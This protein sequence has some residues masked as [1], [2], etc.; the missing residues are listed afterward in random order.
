[1][2]ADDL[3]HQAQSV[4]QVQLT[5]CAM[6][7][8]TRGSGAQ[9][10]WEAA[11]TLHTDRLTLRPPRVDDRDDV[12]AT[13]DAEVC[14]WQG[15]DDTW[16]KKWAEMFEGSYFRELAQHKPA[17]SPRLV[18]CESDGAVI[19][20]YMYGA[21]R[22]DDKVLTLGWWLG[23]SGRGRGL[24]TESLQAILEFAH[25]HGLKTI[26]MGTGID[27]ARARRQIESTGAEVT[28]Q[29]AHQLPNGQNVTAIWYRHHGPCPPA[30]PADA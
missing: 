9:R 21:P 13:I 18:V 26:E 23:A 14:R 4:S 2:L 24:G 6:R 17:I 25:A 22:S 10:R 8:R 30:Q 16:L 15:Y 7:A 19:G 3:P 28:E 20:H 27:N 1:V 11:Q 29:G 5:S 12:L